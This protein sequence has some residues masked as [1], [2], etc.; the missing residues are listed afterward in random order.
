MV[1]GGYPYTPTLEQV[2][3]EFES[4]KGARGWGEG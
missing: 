4:P 3:L 2:T 1:G